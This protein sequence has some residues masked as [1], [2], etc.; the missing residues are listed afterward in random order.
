[1]DGVLLQ[2]PAGMVRGDTEADRGWHVLRAR[3]VLPLLRAPTLHGKKRGA[4]TKVQCTN[5]WWS[6]DLVSGQ[7]DEIGAECLDID[8]DFS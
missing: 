5:A 6:A 2:F 3:A 4:F 1:M 8:R 7:G